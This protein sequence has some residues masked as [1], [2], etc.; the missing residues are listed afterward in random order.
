MTDHWVTLLT[1]L[2]LSWAVWGSIRPWHW[3]V[4]WARQ[5]V[6][7]RQTAFLR[8]E[9]PAPIW[10][11]TRL[12]DDESF[13]LYRRSRWRPARDLFGP[14]YLEVLDSY[15][16]SIRDIMRAYEVMTWKEPTNVL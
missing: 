5:Q 2:L 11:I 14:R 1:I 10:S 7:R 12:I 16:Y 4:T 8:A 13:A 15:Y 3:A 6:L 9:H